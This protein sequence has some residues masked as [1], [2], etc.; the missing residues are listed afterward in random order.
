MSTLYFET[1]AFIKLLIG[2]PGS[3]TVLQAWRGGSQMLASPLLFVEARAGLA[4]ARRGRRMTAEE[5]V[6]AKE[7]MHAM[8]VNVNELQVDVAV[9]AEAE[10]LAER[11]GLRG[12]DAVHLASA[13]F[14]RV[15]ALVTADAALVDAG[16]RCGLTVVD[17]RR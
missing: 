11:E 8:R 9:L 10:D 7:A 16:Q 13:L 5:F 6:V 1:S 17:A 15:D 3:P 4:A 2:E 14:A 12:Y